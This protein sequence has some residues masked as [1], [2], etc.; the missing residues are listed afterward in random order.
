MIKEFKK[1]HPNK[2]VINGYWRDFDAPYDMRLLVC[3]IYG[4]GDYLTP[5]EIDHMSRGRRFILM[6]SSED[7]DS[8][9]RT[10]EITEVLPNNDKFKNVSYKF[11]DK[12]LIYSNFL[13]KEMIKWT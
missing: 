11:T 5:E 6:F 1:K 2:E 7:N 9:V 4:V 3:G 13:H 8:P 10:K 12:Y